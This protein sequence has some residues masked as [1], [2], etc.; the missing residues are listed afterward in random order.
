MLLPGI[1]ACAV[2]GC[3][4]L[5]AGH[6]GMQPVGPNLDEQGEITRYPDGSAQRTVLE[7]FRALQRNDAARALAFYA[8]DTRMSANVIRFERAAG[9]R[10]FAQAQLPRVISVR[11]GRA[12]A[13]VFTLVDF[14]WSAPDGRGYVSTRP[15]AFPLRLSR[16]RWQLVD[17]YFL[18]SAPF[19]VPR[20]P[21][22]TC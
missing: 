13:T 12:R 16:G 10:F 7:W 17:N 21:C 5:G 18:A 8:P 2:G 15:Q 20:G 4:H 1:A 9:A 14:R 19:L 6:K 3:G 11:S 22:T